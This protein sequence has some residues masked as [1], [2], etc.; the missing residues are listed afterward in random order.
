MLDNDCP[1]AYFN[2][3]VNGPVA[4]AVRLRFRHTITSPWVCIVSIGKRGESTSYHGMKSDDAH[5]TDAFTVVVF[6][7]DVTAG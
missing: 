2:L 1:L 5:S 6:V 3:H 4:D 7:V